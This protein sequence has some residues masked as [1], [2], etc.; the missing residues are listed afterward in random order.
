MLTDTPEKFAIEQGT[1]VRI[2]RKKLQEMRRLS[3]MEGST[4]TRGRPN[5][6]PALQ[7]MKTAQT[8]SL[9]KLRVTYLLEG[10][11]AQQLIGR[12]MR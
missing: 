1:N 3:R 5:D 7:V 4:K 9:M 8:F 6:R 11:R 12:L 2:K 10:L